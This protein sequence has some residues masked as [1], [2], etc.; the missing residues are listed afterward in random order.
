LFGVWE[1]AAKIISIEIS[2]IHNFAWNFAWTWKDRGREKQNIPSRLLK[3]HGSTLLSSFV[4]TLLAD[5]LARIL[6]IG[7][8]LDSFLVNVADSLGGVPVVAGL[9]RIEIFCFGIGIAMGMISNYL[10]SDLWVFR[11]KVE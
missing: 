7:S 9:F 4:I 5:W 11:K 2:I 3:Y 10:L 1:L 6:L 8:F